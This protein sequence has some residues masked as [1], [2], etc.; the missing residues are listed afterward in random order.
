MNWRQRRAVPG[1]ESGATVVRKNPLLRDIIF[2]FCSVDQFIWL[3]LLC[4]AVY[5]LAFVFMGRD[6]GVVVAAWGCGSL[7]LTTV[8][9]GKLTFSAT[10]FPEFLRTMERMRFIQIGDGIRWTYNRP[11]WLKWRNSDLIVHRAG[12]SIII[13]GPISTL[14]YLSYQLKN[15]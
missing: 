9:P 12:Q 8:A 10:A 5:L 15:R 7:S 6:W 3:F 14:T 13:D 1:A 2:P 4:A 11:S